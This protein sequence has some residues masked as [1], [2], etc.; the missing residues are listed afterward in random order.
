MKTTLVLVVILLLVSAI[1]WSDA[2]VLTSSSNS[3]KTNKLTI[4]NIIHGGDDSSVVG[5]NAHP[6]ST[7]MKCGPLCRMYCKF[8]FEKD[9]SGC[10]YCKCKLGPNGT[11]FS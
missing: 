6:K 5:V 1:F 3:I 11:R 7:T 10:P 9:E 4:Q 2:V 8:G